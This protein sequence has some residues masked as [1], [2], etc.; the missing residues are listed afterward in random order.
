MQFTELKYLVPLK[1]YLKLCVQNA[2]RKFELRIR[3]IIVNYGAL[4]K[5]Y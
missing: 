2:F 5:V 4:V 1:S 3:L